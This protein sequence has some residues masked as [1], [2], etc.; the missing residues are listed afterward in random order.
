MAFDEAINIVGTVEANIVGTLLHLNAIELGEEG[1]P[2]ELDMRANGSNK[3]L[4]NCSSN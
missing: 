1:V 2:G 4:T 3:L